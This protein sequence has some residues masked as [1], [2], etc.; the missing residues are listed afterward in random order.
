[1]RKYFYLT[2][3]LISVLCCGFAKPAK[4]YQS[5]GT[6]HASN[7]Y[8]LATIIWHEIGSGTEADMQQ[9]ANVVM[10]RYELYKSGAGGNNVQIGDILTQKYAFSGSEKYLTANMS[11]SDILSHIDGRMGKD[12]WEKCLKIAN[13]ALGGQLKDITQGATHYRT[14]NRQ[15]GSHTTFWGASALNL[16]HNGP[17]CFFKDI[18]MGALKIN[19]KTIASEGKV[20]GQFN[21]AYV[22][23][24]VGGGG[25]AYGGSGGGGG[26][27]GYDSGGFTDFTLTDQQYKAAC[28]NAKTEDNSTFE[29]PNL[30][31]TAILSG[32]EMM[33]KKIYSSLGVLYALGNSLM[34][35]ATDIGYTCIGLTVLGF[36]ACIIKLVNLQFWLC[37]A[38]IYITAF[39]LSMSIGM[40][41]IDV[42]FKIGFALLMLPISIALWPFEPTRG[43]LSEN[44][45]IIIR[46]AM[47]FALVSIGVSFAIILIEQGILN[48]IDENTFNEA[49]KEKSGEKLAEDFSLDSMRILV[50]VFCL[51]FGLKIVTSSVND[52][53]NKIF[54]DNL[55]GGSSPMH[56]MGTQA[57]G[58]VQSRTITP[59]AALV[60]DMAKNGAGHLMM[61]T[62]KGISDISRGDFT[63]LRNIASF[64]KR[65]GNYVG[66]KITHPREILQGGVRVAGKVVQAGASG[67]AAIDR[68]MTDVGRL[69]KPG[70]YSEAE[71]QAQKIEY[72]SNSKRREDKFNSGVDAVTD[73]T[74]AGIDF[75]GDGAQKLATAGANKVA[76]SKVGK[77]TVAGAQAVGLKAQK[78]ASGAA[79]L[80]IQGAAMASQGAHA[81]EEFTK[82]KIASGAAAAASLATGNTVDKESMRGALHT[83]KEAIKGVA[84]MAGQA[85][86]IGAK[87]GAKNYDKGNILL[88]PGNILGATATIA[89]SPLNL[90][91]EKLG[92]KDTWVNLGKA[93]TSAHTYAAPFQKQTYEQLAML[94]DKHILRPFIEQISTG[95]TKAV[96]V[97]DNGEPTN[98]SG[99]AKA[100]AHIGNQIGQ[101][102]V[103]GAIDQQMGGGTNLAQRI[104]MKT[105]RDTT[106]I[107]V[108]TGVSTVQTTGAVTGSLLQKFGK[109]LT[110]NKPK[111]KG[112]WKEYWHRKEEEEKKQ[113]IAEQEQRETDETMAD[114]FVERDHR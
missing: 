86:V 95:G 55:F 43:K 36:E 14:C 56:R 84:M 15:T 85:A 12:A 108:R 101:Y 1:M 29:P 82:D 80:A 79:G 111:D 5:S 78:I 23:S 31:N 17:H 72:D 37:G 18:K 46:N 98:M 87:E 25:G 65:A 103:G 27:M 75:L 59:A 70:L 106:K 53:L 52:Y 11:D 39:F 104:I 3:L 97:D 16:E 35:Y 83:G 57:F 4:A 61:A 33:L 114:N 6:Y 89:V 50:I 94:A 30:F 88:T 44:F 113:R 9:V 110:Q 92:K 63:P 68:E 81:V 74:N 91:Y 22:G 42:S 49:L 99:I 105:S 26:G 19:G 112:Y 45:S 28:A 7:A 48:G 40:Y 107:F 76:N 41:F 96:G 38:A 69:I 77:A 20:T 71:R 54:P 8:M 51:I 24:T 32:M 64:S 58:Y 62:G 90:P 102:K 93:A 2:F 67:I 73:F 21:G 109:K 60:G 34:C 66:H 13:L 100:A 47:L 10:N